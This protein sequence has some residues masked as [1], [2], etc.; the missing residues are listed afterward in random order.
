MKSKTDKKLLLVLAR[1][2]HI[3]YFAN[4]DPNGE[5]ENDTISGNLGEALEMVQELIK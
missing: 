4:L 5:P 2:I 1:K 3:A